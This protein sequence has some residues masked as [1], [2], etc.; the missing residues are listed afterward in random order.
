[1]FSQL[2]EA[3]K[4]IKRMCAAAETQY[5]ENKSGVKWWYL[6]WVNTR[7]EAAFSFKALVALV[8]TSQLLI[9][10]SLICQCQD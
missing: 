4:F 9:G 10:Q 2:L 6:G 5:R 7:W 1:M 3:Y 8:R